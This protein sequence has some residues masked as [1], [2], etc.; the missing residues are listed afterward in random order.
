MKSFGKKTSTLVTIMVLLGGLVLTG[1][2]DSAATAE[3]SKFLQSFE[4]KVNELNEFIKENDSNKIAEIEKEIEAMKEDWVEIRNEHADDLTPQEMG[5]IVEE[6]N[7]IIVKL[8]EIEKN[9]IG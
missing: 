8:I 9:K 7:R 4:N 5:R 3:M 1:C 2:G 6:Y